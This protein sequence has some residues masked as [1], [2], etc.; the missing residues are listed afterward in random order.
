MVCLPAP[1][2]SSGVASVL[3]HHTHERVAAILP[4]H[5]TLGFAGKRA[6]CQ[7]IAQFDPAAT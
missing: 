1:P 6:A 3:D 2:H 7:I 4:L 5:F